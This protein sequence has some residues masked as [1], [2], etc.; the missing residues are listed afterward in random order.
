[1]NLMRKIHVIHDLKII[2]CH[3]ETFS[4]F[5]LLLPKHTNTSKEYFKIVTLL[6]P[7]GS[8][9]SHNSSSLSSCGK[10][11]LIFFFRT[12][13]V[14]PCQNN[15][16]TQ[17]NIRFKCESILAITVFPRNTFSTSKNI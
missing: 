7:I 12:Q 17:N 3:L 14:F 9:L 8:K 1:M 13:I 15:G 6:L 10:A 11:D 2:H 16:C 5:C 4:F